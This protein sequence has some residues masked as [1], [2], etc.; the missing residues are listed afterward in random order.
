MDH[1]SRRLIGASWSEEH[2]VQAQK[3]EHRE[4]RQGTKTKTRKRVRQGR[5][6][7]FG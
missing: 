7:E 1:G 6:R 5:A 2:F 3:H 4:W